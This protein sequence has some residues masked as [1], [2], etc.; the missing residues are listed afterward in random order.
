MMSTEPVFDLLKDTTI[1][2]IRDIRCF[3]WRPGRQF[4]IVV[5]RDP[6]DNPGDP[7]DRN[8][9]FQLTGNFEAVYDYLEEV[10]PHGG[11]DKAEDWV[12]GL[13]LVL[14][15]MDWSG[16]DKYVLWFG[17]ENAH[18]SQ[19]STETHDRHDNQAPLLTFLIQEA[20]ALRISFTIVNVKLPGSAGCSK[21]AAIWKSIHESAY[22]R[23]FEII[24]LEYE[25]DMGEWTGTGYLERFTDL[26]EFDL[27]TI[28]CR[29]RSNIEIFD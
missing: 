6:V 2:Y 12:G 19:F 13:K 8:E 7:L 14:Y 5:Y 29:R 20:A 24:D 22:W 17:A 27:P 26:V 9:L 11:G 16:G 21:T 18:G 25:W 1:D 10:K 3:S 15:E 4:G 23:S 28:L